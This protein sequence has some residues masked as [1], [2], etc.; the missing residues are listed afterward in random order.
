MV[1]SQR[2]NVP[3]AKANPFAAISFAF[4]AFESS[5]PFDAVESV[6]KNWVEAYA[7]L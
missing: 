7:A 6:E 5:E 4:A 3:A 2:S 1:P